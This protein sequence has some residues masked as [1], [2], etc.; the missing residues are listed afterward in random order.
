[1]SLDWNGTYRAEFDQVDRPSLAT[2]SDRK[3]YALQYLALDPHIIASDGVEIHGRIDVLGNTDPV[4]QNTQI[5]QVLGQGLPQPPAAGNT[6]GGNNNVLSANNKPYTLLRVSEAYLN[7]NQEYGTLIAGRA[8]Y[9][10]GMGLVYSAGNGPFDHYAT[11]MDMVGYKFIVGNISFM[12][13]V[14]KSAMQDNGQPLANTDDLMLEFL[15]NAK[16]SNS[17]L[18]GNFMQRTAPQQ[19]ND[20]PIGSGLV[21]GQGS[22]ITD[23]YSMKTVDIFFSRSWDT[24]KFRFEAAT[25]TGNFGAEDINSSNVSENSYGVAVEMDFLR[26]ESKWDWQLRFGAASGDDP[27]STNSWEGFAFNRNY[28]VAQLLFNHRLGQADFLRTGI[29]RDASRSD[30]NSFDDEAISNVYYLSPKIRYAFNEHF[31]LLNTLTYARLMVNPTGAQGLKKDLGIG[32]GYR[33]ELS[34]T[35]QHP[36]GKLF[37]AVIPGRGF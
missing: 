17:V 2:P 24:F 18:G 32:V 3:V 26:P 22:F 30:S 28:D 19:L 4:Y 33:P 12:P 9:E 29:I 31:D 5:G 27:T 35:V 11:I 1:M 36:V 14:A 6:A 25:V 16:D 8:P 34:P 20:V 7:V 23:K 10:F 15:Y 21:G 13:V 37:G